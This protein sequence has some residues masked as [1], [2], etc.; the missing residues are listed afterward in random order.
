MRQKMSAVAMLI[1]L[2]VVLSG[3]SLV[4]DG[5]K[6]ASEIQQSMAASAS[7]STLT[8]E[9][10]Q[11]S[12]VVE[13]SQS[14]IAVYMSASVTVVMTADAAP[15][16]IADVSSRIDE[17][18]RGA[19]LQPFKREFTVTAGEASIRQTDF[20]QAP[21]DFAAELAYWDA[22]KSA[23]GPGISLTLGAGRDG[24]LQRILSTGTDS[25]VIAIADHADALAA[26]ITPNG[27]ETMWRLPG[28]FGYSDW[29]GP[30]PD[31]RILKFLAA[32][33]SVTNL[34]DDSVQESPPGVYVN[35]PGEGADFA[36]Q[37]AFVANE[38][39]MSVDAAATW[40]ITL[41]FAREALATGL[42]ALQVSVQSYGVDT[43]DQ[44]SFHIGE[45]TELNPMFPPS[46]A[47]RKLVADLVAGGVSLPESAAGMCLTFA[48]P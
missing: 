14:V 46:A 44:A 48:T 12:D 25:A 39:G 26:L 29:L 9:L 19:D 41:R 35:V 8:D 1:A 13:A 45:C 16:A 32:M 30:L 27:V 38:P 21:F 17:S 43:A 4:N 20:T 5:R 34:L 40:Q 3:C 15:S 33:A 47:D 2:A 10:R 6:I 7:L 36:P 11:R 23:I 22:V 42:P 31:P 18:M 24:S 37:F 28:I